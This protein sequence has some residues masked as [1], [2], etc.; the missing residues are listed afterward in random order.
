[1]FHQVEGLLIDETSNFGHLKGL[2]EDFLQAFF[3]RTIC[4]FAYVHRIFLHGTVCRSRHSV[5]EV[6][7]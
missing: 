3:E 7:R 4:R 2:L 6:F 1:M 5:R